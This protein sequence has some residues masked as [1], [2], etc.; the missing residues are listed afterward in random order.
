M[1]A[2]DFGWCAMTTMVCTDGDHVTT[3]VCTGPIEGAQATFNPA[4]AQFES[5]PN[6]QF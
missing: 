6:R 5:I 1:K 2:Q 4:T 3:M